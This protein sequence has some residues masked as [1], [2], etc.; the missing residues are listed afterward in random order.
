MSTIATSPGINDLDIAPIGRLLCCG[1]FDHTVKLGGY[2]NK[3][4]FGS[5][6]RVSNQLTRISLREYRGPRETDREM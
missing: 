2:V 1:M 3:I 6:G 5:G 4:N